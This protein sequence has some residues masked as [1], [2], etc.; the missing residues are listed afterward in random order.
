MWLHRSARGA[1]PLDETTTRRSA[2]SREAGGEGGIHCNVRRETVG[3]G[4]EVN[5][6]LH[7][8]AITTLTPGSDLNLEQMFEL[9]R[10]AGLQRQARLEVVECWDMISIW[11]HWIEEHYGDL[12]S[13]CHRSG[14]DD[15]PDL[16]LVFPEVVVPF[17]HT[18]LQPYPLGW[19]EDLSH[20]VFSESCSNVPSLSQPLPQNRDELIAIMG[21]WDSA[22]TDVQDEWI[23]CAKHLAATIREKMKGLPSGGIIGIVDRISHGSDDRQFLAKLAWDFINSGRCRDFTPYTLILL[24]RWNPI[25]FYSSLIRR[26]G[27]LLVERS[28]R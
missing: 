1:S 12:V 18:R 4:R 23:A 15:P 10:T 26:G 3:K 13:L 2:E 27:E 25:Q 17:E 22:W 5:L 7:P 24:S 9:A 16:E 6:P 14:Q 28:E 19:S 20:T 8:M 21:A 11:R